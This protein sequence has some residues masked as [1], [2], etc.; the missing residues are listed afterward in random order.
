MVSP[1]V[2]IG[3]RSPR[4]I[5]AAL[6]TTAMVAMPLPAS[7]G[8]HWQLPLW[9]Q[10]FSPQPA[11]V[12][13]LEGRQGGITGPGMT[14]SVVE[15]SLSGSGSSGGS[16]ASRVSFGAAQRSGAPL[17]QGIPPFRKPNHI[18]RPKITPAKVNLSWGSQR[19]PRPVPPAATK[20]GIGEA[21]T[22]Q[23]T[24]RPLLTLP[25]GREA[26]NA[27]RPDGRGTIDIKEP[28]PGVPKPR[29]GSWER[30]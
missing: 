6:A 14:A 17:G 12:D 11:S 3:M 26:W 18:E 29:W 23:P 30:P 16:A 21:R 1:A 5:L 25:S 19:H 22:F 15:G 7:A 4:L 2:E 28:R 24:E 27:R 9:F 10:W 8:P 13:P 20:P